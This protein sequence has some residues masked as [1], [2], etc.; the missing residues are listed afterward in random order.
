MGTPTATSNI[1]AQRILPPRR[2][3]DDN[4]WEAVNLAIQHHRSKIL[5]PG[6]GVG[7]QCISVVPWF[8]VDAARTLHLGSKARARSTMPNLNSSSAPCS[9]SLA[10]P[11]RAHNLLGLLIK[12][13]RGP[14][15]EPA[16]TMRDLVAAGASVTAYDPSNQTPPS[17][18]SPWPNHWKKPYAL[19]NASSFL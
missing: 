5:S 13:C 8:L 12:Q 9:T 19:L 3:L 1:A 4:I 18:A 14:A 11:R 15:R 17:M 16:I 7:G 10:P 2:S 6:I